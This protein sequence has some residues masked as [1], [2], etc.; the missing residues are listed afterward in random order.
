M[1]ARFGTRTPAFRP[2]AAKEPARLHVD[3]LCRTG[4][5]YSS[6]NILVHDRRTDCM[7]IW[8]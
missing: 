3:R 2:T 4:R 7:W 6:N 8:R 1:L 5:A